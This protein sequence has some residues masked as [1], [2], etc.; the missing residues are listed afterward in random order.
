VSTPAV[1]PVLP[2]TVPVEGPD[3]DIPTE[4]GEEDITAEGADEVVVAGGNPPNSD[5]A[6]TSGGRG[7]TVYIPMVAFPC[8]SADRSFCAIPRWKNA[9]V[10]LASSKAWRVALRF[11]STVSTT[12]LACDVVF[13]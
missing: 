8:F 2:V 11:C 4:G 7:N 5:G 13:L 9:S 1:D 10:R 6:C 12:C 3:E